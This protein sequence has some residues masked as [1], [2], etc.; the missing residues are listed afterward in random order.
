MVKFCPKCGS[1]MIPRKEGG[2]SIWICPK[3]GYKEEA[4]NEDK[5]VIKSKKKHSPRDKLVVIEDDMPPTAS[6]LKG[7]V[8]CPKCGSDEVYYWMV[9]TRSADEPMTRFYRCKKCGYTWREYE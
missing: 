8:R 6:L 5:V 7:V 1:I 2:K 4:T 3:C 9:Q